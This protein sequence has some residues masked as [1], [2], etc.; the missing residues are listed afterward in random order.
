METFD[1]EISDDEDFED[2]LLPV[3]TPVY[4]QQPSGLPPPVS[5]TPSYNSSQFDPF[6]PQGNTPSNDNNNDNN[7]IVLDLLSAPSS[8]S[9]APVLI[10]MNPDA[11]GDLLGGSTIV[12][13]QASKA[14]KDPKMKILLYDD[15]D[16]NDLLM[17]TNN[18]AK[19]EET[20]DNFVD[21]DENAKGGGFFSRLGNKIRST[22]TKEDSKPT[23]TES[24]TNMEILQGGGNSLPH[25]DTLVPGS[26][27]DNVQEENS[28]DDDSSIHSSDD[29][30][31]LDGNGKSLPHP[32]EIMRLNDTNS[33]EKKEEPEG[34]QL[35]ENGMSLPHPETIIPLR[36]PSQQ[37]VLLKTLNED[38]NSGSSQSGD[39]M[40]LMAALEAAS[41][42]SDSDEDMYIEDAEEESEDSSSSS[43]NSESGHY[44]DGN[45]NSLP[46]PDEHAINKSSGHG[47]SSFKWRNLK[48]SFRSTFNNNQKMDK[49]ESEDEKEFADEEG[50]FMGSSRKGDEEMGYSDG[51]ESESESESDSDFDDEDPSKKARVLSLVKEQSKNPKTQLICLVSLIVFILLFIVT[52]VAVNKKK[53]KEIA[54]TGASGTSVAAPPTQAPFSF[55]G[56]PCYDE[57]V[58][59]DRDGKDLV[60]GTDT[61][62]DIACYSVE[63]PVH[64]RFKR[65]RPA[66][67]LDWVG[68]FSSRSMFMDKLWK[69]HYDGLYLCGDQP[70]PKED[71]NNKEGGPPR[72]Q[73]TKAPPITT[74]GEYRLFLVKDSD[75]PYEFVKHTAAFH[76]VESSQLCANKDNIFSP[77]KSG[78]Q[79]ESVYIDL[80]TEVPTNPATSYT[81][82]NSIGTRK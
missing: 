48:T 35:D 43:S 76:V 82:L 12:T 7:N 5:S 30:D 23:N 20:A 41:A 81:S 79:G 24:D 55:D 31:G 4:L 47:M 54:S 1:N 69:D 77:P 49:L 10:P 53:N 78:V 27:R 9:N 52:P 66:S 56:T 65:C 74:P 28:S 62:E 64:F 15:D 32:E 63:E 50:R 11:D 22:P 70:C 51:S 68:V 46:H 40:R 60:N 72:V 13:K 6:A 2:E 18:A 34:M 14:E 38:D 21:D 17:A 36:P 73:T 25:P 29:E 3:A 80:P 58:L 39:N 75:W 8:S 57:I 33:N 45:G 26:S 61:S 19:E 44:L 42:E 37:D 16:D 59:T 71:P 67:P